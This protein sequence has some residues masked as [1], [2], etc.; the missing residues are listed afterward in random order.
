MSVLT[1]HSHVLPALSTQTLPRHV[2]ELLR[3]VLKLVSDELE[4]GLNASIRDFE[5]HLHR[6]VDRLMDK[7]VR[8]RWLTAQDTLVRSRPELLAHFL[9]ALEA[10]LASL[11][12]PQ[13]IRGHLQTRYRPG[14]ELA[15]VNDVEIEET[16]A[17]TDAATRA[18]LQNSL[19][20]FLL[21]QR[22]GVLAG[23]PA[24]DVETLP[25]GPQALCRSIRYA[26]ERLGLDNTIRVM[27][28]RSFERQVMPTYGTLV[29]TI[30]IDLARNG[31]LRNLQYVPVRARRVE[32]KVA[33]S[34]AESGNRGAKVE[35]QQGTLAELR[36]RSVSEAAL[37][38]GSGAAPTNPASRQ[39]AD[40]LAA[41]A[42]AS[43][44]ESAPPERAFSLL[45][46]LL[47]GRRQLLGKLSP[48]RSRVG[49]EPPRVVS[50][51]DLQEALSA[52]QSRPI[53]PLVSQG[54]SQPR[55]IGHLKQDMLAMLRRASPNQ[56]APALA[57]EHNDALDLMSM[58]YDSLMKDLKPDSHAAALVSKLQVPLMRVA[59]QDKTL[60]TRHEHPARQMLNALAESSSQWLGEDGDDA[61]LLNQ[62]N[63]LVDRAVSG[64]QGDPAVFSKVLE[65]LNGHLQML[66]RK[67]EA[68]ERRH[69]EAAR[70]K[71]KLTLAREH[72]T[73][74]VEALIKSQKLP[75][76][77]RTM[78]SQAWADVMAL[79]SLRQGAD[80][81]AW[82]AQLA[83]A[84]RLI[85][86]SQPDEASAVDSESR[87]R[88]QR[89]I[90]DGLSKVGYQ[91]EDVEA[92]ATR[93]VHPDSPSKDEASSRTELTMR[94]KARAR[95]GE[96]LNGRKSRHLALT[97]AE[98]AQ[99]H[100]LKDIP[101]G[102]WF[103]FVI[104]PKGDR[105]RRR[106]SWL[107]AAT[108]EVLFV[109]Q[110]GQKNA[111]YTLESLARLLAKGQVA[112]LEEDKTSMIDHAWENVLNS[113]RSFAVPAA[114][115]AVKSP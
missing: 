73:R 45:Q 80:S 59:L 95:L 66:S 36:T 99:L 98:E 31:V 64:Y 14:G 71:E 92:I 96:D 32:Q 67:A 26:H 9:G 49:R 38:T 1:S 4:R 113:L 112:V 55:N 93:L 87:M 13:I 111:E 63:S 79:T 110:R 57:D 105:V 75:R 85:Q 18:E 42:A 88:L 48:D 41:L 27:F 97:S 40:L 29:E 39:A 16:S 46:Q 90:E 52:M 102:T 89:E 58:L 108:G 101:L 104:N 74:A 50:T 2:R 22:F 43:R 23:R 33:E 72:A 103:E 10:E 115:A 37:H 3:G 28:Y 20:L 51:N 114:D 15:L 8:E 21:G 44:N 100:R 76:F 35:G 19:Q 109:N 77:T 91:G 78:L 11:H 24:F 69:V 61:G 12:E 84:E 65:E 107:S 56:E 60:F 25:V 6:Q 54:R 86:L 94:L 81:E 53:A 30:N 62:M 47:A 5:Q 106:L 70:G 82:H 83:V 7:A 34:A 17:L 68:A